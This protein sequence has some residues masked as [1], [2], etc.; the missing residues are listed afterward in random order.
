MVSAAKLRRAQERMMSSPA[1]TR[2]AR[3]AVLQSLAS[4]AASSEDSHPLLAPGRRPAHI[5]TVLVTRR[6]TRV[7]ADRR[8]TPVAIRTAESVLIDEKL[9]DRDISESTRDR[10][11]GATTSSA[12]HAPW[13]VKHMVA[14]WAD[15]LPRRAS[16]PSTQEIAG[17]PDPAMYLDPA[18]S[19]V[20]YLAYQRIQIGD[21]GQTDRAS[22][23]LPIVSSSIEL[24]PSDG[25]TAL[26]DYIY[27]PSAKTQL[28][29]A[30]LP[31]Y[32]EQIIFQALLESAAAEHARA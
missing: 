11:E 23:L 3:V 28:L 31:H 19:T 30:L 22:R 1:R 24:D 14:E 32:V 15:S 2:T 29:A 5:E 21:P 16:I 25:E 8:S 4:R 26:T 20:I 17:R 18:R 27:E 10:Q 12:F 9:R 7:C 6:A 13:K